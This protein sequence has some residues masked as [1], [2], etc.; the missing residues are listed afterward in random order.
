MKFIGVLYFMC[1]RPVRLCGTEYP[2]EAAEPERGQRS[3]VHQET[4]G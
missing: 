4:G 2:T 1:C 3:H